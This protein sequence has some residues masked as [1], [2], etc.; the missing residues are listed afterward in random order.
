MDNPILARRFALGLVNKKKRTCTD[1]AV[2]ADYKG[3]N[4]RKQKDRQILGLCLRNK[5]RS[6]EYKSDD[7]ASYNQCTWNSF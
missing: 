6:V 7:G 4:E 1:F 5:K 3:K 2:L